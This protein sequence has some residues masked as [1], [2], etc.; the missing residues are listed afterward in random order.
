[1]NYGELIGEAFSIA[2]RNRF[3][4]IFGIFSGGGATFVSPTNFG[5]PATPTGEPTWAVN[6]ARWVED[7]V[8]LAIFIFILTIL[9]IILVFMALSVLCR[10]ALTESVG[11][12][13][14][15][16]SRGFGSTLRGGLSHFWRV[17]LQALLIILIWLAVLI[18]VYAI[19]GAVLFG[20]FA[21][22][23]SVTDST[24]LRI[25]I[26]LVCVFFILL[27]VVAVII[28]MVA[29]ALIQQLAL[30]DLILGNSGIATSIGNGYRLFRRNLG[31]TLLLLVIQIGISFGVGIVLL[32]VVTLLGLLLSIPVTILSDSSVSTVV[33]IAGGLLFSVPVF[34]L[35]GFLGTYY[36]AYWTLAYLRLTADD[37]QPRIA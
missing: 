3:L 21:G 6:F 20:L 12:I 37:T 23:L 35:G 33:A 14:R 32:I 15:G 9:A 22:L 26:T 11:A 13:A 8:G 18:P 24:A 2:W 4:W 25:V 10:A 27:L 1:V 16:D 31:R 29:L 30:R 28:A 34:V 7:N 19:L 5:T 36:Q 17:L